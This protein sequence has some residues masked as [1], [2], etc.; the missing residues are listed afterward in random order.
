MPSLTSF[1]VFLVTVCCV[2]SWSLAEH[3]QQLRVPELLRGQ[4]DTTC[5]QTLNLA[6]TDVNG[7]RKIIPNFYG[8]Y[9]IQDRYVNGKPWYLKEDDKDLRLYFNK[10]CSYWLLTTEGAPGHTPM[11][12]KHCVAQIYNSHS[13]DMCP[14]IGTNKHWHYWIPSATVW[15][16]ATDSQLRFDVVISTL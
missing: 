14:N 10:D 12:D 15:V 8:N 3:Q 11:G 2:S 4:Q 9:H 13:S 5:P 7:P 16:H 6:G 1:L